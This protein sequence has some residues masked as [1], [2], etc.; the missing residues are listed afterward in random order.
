MRTHLLHGAVA[1]VVQRDTKP[2]R[3]R[4]VTEE[5]FIEMRDDERFV[6]LTDEQIRDAIRAHLGDIGFTGADS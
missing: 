3:Y 2:A 1:D 4:R 5:M 6:G